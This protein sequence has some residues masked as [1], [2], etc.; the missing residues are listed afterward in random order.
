M[1]SDI[2]SA[3][4]I[5]T[6]NLNFLLRIT[7]DM[8]EQYI[9][10]IY[11]NYTQD[12]QAIDKSQANMLHKNEFKEIKKILIDN[13]YLRINTAYFKSLLERQTT[14]QKQDDPLKNEHKAEKKQ[15]MQAL[16]IEEQCLKL[17]KIPATILLASYYASKNPER[18][19]YSS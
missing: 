6:R 5:H 18:S 12:Q 4:C 1:A 3:F 13:P 7:K 9:Y 11:K 17:P 8:S 10:K 14:K 19:E 15:A 2:V 16:G